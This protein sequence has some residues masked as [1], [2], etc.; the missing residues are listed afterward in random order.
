ME[1]KFN[2]IKSVYGSNKEVIKN[3]MTL[4]EIECFDLDCTYSKGTFWTGL[5]EPKHKSDLNPLNDTIIQANSENLPFNNNSFKSIMYDPPFLVNC[6]IHSEACSESKYPE[7]SSIIH[8]RYGKYAS[9]QDLKNN[10]FNTLKELYRLCKNNGY[11]VMK[12]QDTII[13]SKNHFTHCMVMNMGIEV[14]FHPKDLFIVTTKFRLND[15]GK[16]WK[17]QQHAR[18]YHSYFWVFKKVRPKVNYDVKV[19]SEIEIKFSGI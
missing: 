9:F 10:Y 3:I 1:N 11:V 5:P 19:L 12:C 8:K 6:A 18:K 14:G 7:N 15:F 4:Y 2:I 17:K 16:K 13:G